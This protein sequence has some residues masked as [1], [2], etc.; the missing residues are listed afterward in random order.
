MKQINQQTT[1]RDTD[2]A[3]DPQNDLPDDQSTKQAGNQAVM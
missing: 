3:T 2:V 1:K